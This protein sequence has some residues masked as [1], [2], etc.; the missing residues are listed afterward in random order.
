[1]IARKLSVA[2]L[3]GLVILAAADLSAYKLIHETL[4]RESC[5]LPLDI[6]T[7]MGILGLLPSSTA[8]AIALA[9]I[10]GRLRRQGEG[11]PFLLGFLI[12]ALLAALGFVYAWWLGDTLLM[13]T[14]RSPMAD[15][16]AVSAWSDHLELLFFAGVASVPQFLVATAGG[17]L[18][19]WLGIRIRRD[20]RPATA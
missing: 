15:S 7:S 20:P 19:R 11:S 4:Y 9:L 13:E 12:A 8:I 5:V 2:G 10:A 1:M 3:M 14:V 16:P 6:I 17:L 18:F